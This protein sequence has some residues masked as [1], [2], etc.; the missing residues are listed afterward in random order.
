M[1][2]HYDLTNAEPII[3]DVP[4]CGSTD[5]LRG[6]A[7]GRIGAVTTGLNRY[8]YQNIVATTLADMMGVSDELYDYSEHISNSGSNAATSEATGV[9]NYIKAV[10]N[11]M[12]VWLAEYSQHADDDT[13]ANGAASSAGI[14]WTGTMTAPGDNAEGNWVYVTGTG[15]TTGGAGNLFQIGASTTTVYTA[16]TS[17]DTYMKASTTSDTCI[18]LHMP[19]GCQVVGGSINLSAVAGRIGTM[20][21]GGA[22]A[23]TDVGAAITLQNYIMDKGTSLQPLR[24]EQH[25]GKNFDYATCR[26]Y[27]DL[28]FLDHLCL[29]G[30]VA[31]A[32]L[33]T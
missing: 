2:W 29:G 11:P 8:A 28:F 17:Y 32:P 1:I 3:R 23:G 9:T 31:T 12:A 30:G 33:L 20:V 26:L 13:A 7:I 15:S 21:K 6:A 4:V 25:S 16:C 27:A 5:I 24:V 22:L 10:I 19:Y 18:I 14:I